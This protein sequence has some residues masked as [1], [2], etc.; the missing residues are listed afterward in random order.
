MRPRKISE[1]SL[2]CERLPFWRAD[3]DQH[4]VAFDVILVGEV[5]DLDHGDDFF[6]LLADLVQDAVVADDDEG[7]AR[8]PR[9]LGLADGQAVDVEARE[10]SIPEMWASTPGWF[11]TSAERTCRM[12][13]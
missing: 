5:E 11:I 13:G 7:H 8:E 9:I 10:A 2:I 1:S 3:L 6:Q 4:Q 12:P